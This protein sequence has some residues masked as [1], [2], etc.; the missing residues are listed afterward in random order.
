MTCLTQFDATLLWLVSSSICVKVQLF[1]SSLIVDT[2]LRCVHMRPCT[3]L[4]NQWLNS[5]SCRGTV[6]LQPSHNELSCKTRSKAMIIISEK[7]NFHALFALRRLMSKFEIVS[8]DSKAE[9]RRNGKMCK[10]FHLVDFNHNVD[11]T[12]TWSDKL[13][14]QYSFAHARA[15]TKKCIRISH[16][17]DCIGK[18]FWTETEQ[19]R[20][21]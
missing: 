12:S 6:S 2:L 11:S 7:K 4:I 16:N 13:S 9:R 8:S 3:F 10:M 15:Q 21:I 19:L 18:K 5:L 17:L 14:R 1:L 20:V